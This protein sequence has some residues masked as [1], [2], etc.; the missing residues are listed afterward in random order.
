[1]RVPS[2]TSL[3]GL[4]GRQVGCQ[5][6]RLDLKC[7]DGNRTLQS[8]LP[9]SEREALQCFGT[10]VPTFRPGRSC[11]SSPCCATRLRPDHRKRFLLRPWIPPT[12]HPGKIPT[13]R[14]N[15]RSS[16]LDPGFDGFEAASHAE[17][18]A[19]WQSCSQ[20][21]TWS[22]TYHDTLKIFH[23]F[24][25]SPGAV[26]RPVPA[27]RAIPHAGKVGA[28][29]AVSSSPALTEEHSNVHSFSVSTAL[30]FFKP[31]ELD[32]YLSQ[33]EEAK[34]R[35]HRLLCKQLKLGYTIIQLLA[36][37]VCSVMPKGAPFPRSIGTPL[38]RKNS[39]SV[40]YQP[41]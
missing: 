26:H 24:F 35:D 36:G 2:Q 39:S 40:A 22:R 31:E 41:V 1:L 33:V 21:Y 10:A 38:S 11:G 7:P 23:P 18:R 30:R 8:L 25:L 32:S 16:S 13:D 4:L 15:K 19:L 20:V 14:G 29:Q 28:F 6:F 9:I 12:S 5:P 17:A 3:P 34:K 37:S 27:F